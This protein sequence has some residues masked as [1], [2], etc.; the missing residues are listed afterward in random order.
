MRTFNHVGIPTTEPKAGENYAEGMKLHLTDFSKSPNTIEWLRFDKDS[1]MHPLIQTKTHIAYTV[2]NL[3]EEMKGKPVLLPPTD[4]GD[5]TWIAFIEEEG[6]A[7]ELM[8]KK[9]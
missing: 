3:E 5:G 1:W 8:W 6:I 2:D 4:L 9:S 7:I